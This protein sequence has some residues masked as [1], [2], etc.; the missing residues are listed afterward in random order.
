MVVYYASKPS[1]NRSS[2]VP[3]LYVLPMENHEL[4]LVTSTCTM[5]CYVVLHYY[6]R[7]SKVGLWEMR[8]VLC[9]PHMNYCLCMN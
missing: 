6:T 9:T 3:T 4:E 5:S 2:D 7:H 1:L 8:R